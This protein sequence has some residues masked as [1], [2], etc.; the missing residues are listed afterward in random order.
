MRAFARA[1]RTLTEYVPGP[2]M[3]T[4]ETCM[5]WVHDEI[6]RAAGLPEAIG[7]IPLDE[8]GAT[9]FG[10]RHSIEVAADF[11]GLPLRGA[12]VA[13]QG[14]GAVG[15]HAARFLAELGTVLV[16]VADSTGTAY[17][18]D[19][20]DLRALISTKEAGGSLRDVRGVR[21]MT[22]DEIIGVDCEIWI[23]AARP[24]VLREDN[25]AQL[26]AKIV[27]QG[28]NI[29]ATPAAERML[30]DRGIVNLPDFIANAGGVIC[31]ASELAG[32]DQGAAFARI[33]ESI[34]KNTRAILERARST[35]KV[36]RQAAVELATER[37]NKAMSFRRV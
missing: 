15:R 26:K 4:D 9:G 12:R 28:A 2:D 1:I 29:P 8:I 25:T 23:P 19:G 20:L 18:P 21:W 5:A 16:A 32:N 14:F 33:A 22:R 10:L 35:G 6:G 13:I 24:D 36:E 7:G 11:A 31:A 27:A 30:A 34:R 37:V 17:A 3:G